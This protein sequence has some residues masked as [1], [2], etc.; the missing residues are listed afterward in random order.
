[1]L[2]GL[3]SSG[4]LGAG[5]YLLALVVAM[6]GAVAYSRLSDLLARRRYEAELIDTFPQGVTRAASELV[7]AWRTRF[8]GIELELIALSHRPGMVQ[9][10]SAPAFGRFALDDPLM[11]ED[12]VLLPEEWW[13]P[14]GEPP[15]PSWCPS[16]DLR[17][18]I[19]AAGARLRAAGVTHVLVGS[20]RV[21][22]HIECADA[23][24][25]VRRLAGLRDVVADLQRASVG[26]A[27]RVIESPEALE[28]ARRAA[29]EKLAELRASG[30][31]GLVERSRGFAREAE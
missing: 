2:D 1:M 26:A 22:G 5:V 17:D 13:T 3:N 30:E 14:S 18:A 28:R 25:C 19:E 7:R 15:R 27:R 20:G 10:E 9:M 24:E 11:E 21:R 6:V 8:D 29:D 23:A 31:E 16:S 4:L 12:P